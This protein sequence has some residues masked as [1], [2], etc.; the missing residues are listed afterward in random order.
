MLCW[1][2]SGRLSGGDAVAQ[3]HREVVESPSLEVLQNH[4]DVVP[5]DVVSGHGGVGWG[6]QRSSPIYDAQIFWCF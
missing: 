2:T 3:R 1:G 4:G 5:G 6:S